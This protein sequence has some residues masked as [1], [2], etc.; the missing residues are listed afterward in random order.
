MIILS[1]YITE[2]HKNDLLSF[3][4]NYILFRRTWHLF[5]GLTNREQFLQSSNVVTSA[6][7]VVLMKLS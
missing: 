3:S 1:R 7:R 4:D 6:T 5:D 2:T